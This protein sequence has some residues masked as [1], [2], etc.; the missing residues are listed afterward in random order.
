[1]VYLVIAVS[2][3]PLFIGWLKSRL[4]KKAEQ[5]PAS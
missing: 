5:A 4:A 1:V 3:A 2:V